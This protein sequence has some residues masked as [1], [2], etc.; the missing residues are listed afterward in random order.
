MSSGTLWDVL[1]SGQADADQP[2]GNSQA[3]QPWRSRRVAAMQQ[4]EEDK[5]NAPPVGNESAN[6]SISYS[7]IPLADITTQT[8]ALNFRQPCHG[9]AVNN[10]AQPISFASAP[11]PSGPSSQ[12]KDDEDGFTQDAKSPPF[13]IPI[14]IGEY[15]IPTQ[16]PL[17]SH[18]INPPFRPVHATKDHGVLHS[19]QRHGITVRHLDM[20]PSTD[21]NAKLGD[22]G[23]V[24]GPDG[25]LWMMKSRNWGILTQHGETVTEAPIYTHNNNGLADKPVELWGEY[26]SIKPLRVAEV[27]FVNQSPSNPLLKIGNEF[28]RELTRN[29]MVLKYTDLQTR[30][31]ACDELL[32]VAEFDA[33]ST[34]IVKAYAKKAFAG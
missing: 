19:D 8:N 26:L 7:R 33:E 14:T 18:A 1:D 11:D 6:E 20:R 25:K 15:H 3:P 13:P 9:P 30:R 5:E 27:D 32:K 21:P 22:P 24:M 16:H 28:T 10:R 23:V 29:T 2:A 12:S 4:A 17:T 31:P 34:E